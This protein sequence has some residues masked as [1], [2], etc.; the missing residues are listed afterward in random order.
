MTGAEKRKLD[1]TVEYQDYEICPKRN[2]GKYLQEGIEFFI[3]DM[4]KK[5][6]Y[7]SHD[8]RLRDVHEKVERESTFIVRLAN[9]A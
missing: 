6:V 5:K 2:V 8:L 1:P 3:V 7:S 4:E 9:Y